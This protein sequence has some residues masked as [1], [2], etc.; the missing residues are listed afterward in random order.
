MFMQSLENHL[1]E[2]N[3]RSVTENG[4]VGYKSTRKALL[5]LNFLTS[6]LRSA[7]EQTII[8]KF[9]AAFQENPELALK[10]LFFA[11]DIRGGM[12]ER[13]LFRV[14]LR[15]LVDQCY[16]VVKPFLKLVPEYGRWDDLW[17]LLDSKANKCVA[18]IIREQLAQDMEHMKHGK[19]VSLLAKWLPSAKGKHKAAEEK[20]RKILQLTGIMPTG[21]EGSGSHGLSGISLVIIVAISLLFGALM[22]IGI[23]IY[24]PL[25]ACASLLGMDPLY[26]TPIMLGT[27]AFICP[28]AAIRFAKASY[29]SDKPRYDRKIAVVVTLTGWIGPVIAS[30]VLLALPTTALKWIVVCVMFIVSA[31]MLY[32]WYNNS[33]DAVAEK[34]DAEL[35]SIEADVKQSE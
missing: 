5:D 1:N 32:Q 17:C 27:C 35:A 11:R 8:S 4:A 31:M 10:W 24:A 3:N 16:M 25:L 18:G 12:G 20:A 14:I 29:D 33:A 26:A 34:E 23:G 9:D 6:S 2:C 30:N 28:A 19:P 7:N 15:H 13:R 22:T 21:T